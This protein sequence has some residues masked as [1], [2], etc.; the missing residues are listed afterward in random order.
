MAVSDRSTYV[1]A[2]LTEITWPGTAELFSGCRLKA[3]LKL[4][5]NRNKWLRFSSTYRTVVE[6]G[7]GVSSQKV[8]EIKEG[9]G[10]P[11]PNS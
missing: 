4:R 6:M 7:G 1:T 5:K 8:V 2:Q 3:K 9:E 11:D 10:S